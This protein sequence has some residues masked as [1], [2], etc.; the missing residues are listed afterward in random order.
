MKHARRIE[1][2]V[3][4]TMQKGKEMRKNAGRCKDNSRME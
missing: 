2:E 1:M 3:E 4:H